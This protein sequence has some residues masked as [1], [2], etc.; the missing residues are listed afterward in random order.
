MINDI[1][2]YW[3]LN[4]YELMEKHMNETIQKNRKKRESL[5]T[6]T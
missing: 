5:Q 6:H 1:L 3:N 2:Q 4:D